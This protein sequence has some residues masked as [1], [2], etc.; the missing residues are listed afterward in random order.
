MNAQVPAAVKP[1][2]HTGGQVAAL[3][4]QTLEE[5]FRVANAF[6]VSGLA[7][8]S[9]KTAEA[10]LVAIMAG[11]ELGFAPYQ[12]MQSFAVI[13]GR[14]SIWGDAIPALLW[15]RGFDIEEWFD[16]D[17]NATKAF[18]KV[19]RP[20]GK[21]VERTF[22]LKDAKLANLLGKQGPWQTAQKRMLQMRA[23]AFA[24]RDG[25][26]DVLRGM[27]V[28]EEVADFQ[29][30]REVRAG[31]APT[32]MKARLEARQAGGQGFDADHIARETGATVALD[33]ED[34]IPDFDKEEATDAT[35]EDASTGAPEQTAS[36]QAQEPA[37]DGQKLP[38]GVGPASQV[39]TTVKARKEAF[40]AWAGKT[41][42]AGLKKAR[43][44]AGFA[45]LCN[46]IDAGDPDEVGTSQ[47]LR[48]WLDDLIEEREQAER[49]AAAKG[50]A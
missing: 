18:C 20:S 48:T 4:P 27:P 44:E 41:S 31:P 22:S 43:S 40:E 17:D 47:E 9:L 1:Q 30:I 5:A 24:A 38:G 29:E 34:T 3:V 23:R 32:G 2:L 26:A 10:I 6:A 8:Q 39:L 49:D 35:F 46:D 19:T 25:A 21:I 12:A 28:Y 13:N 33:P 7:P 15:S 50:G 11:A 37:K 45:T 36:E 14:A 16:D 42:A